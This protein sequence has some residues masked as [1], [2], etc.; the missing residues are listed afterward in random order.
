M[1]ASTTFI[2][3][4]P[5]TYAHETFLS[6]MPLR[7]SWL[8]DQKDAKYLEAPSILHGSGCKPIVLASGYH[9]LISRRWV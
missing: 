5:D 8:E 1:V 4:R 3:G 7:R 6:C 9:S 2:R